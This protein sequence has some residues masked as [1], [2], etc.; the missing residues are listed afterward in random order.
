MKYNVIAYPDEDGYPRQETTIIAANREQAQDKAWRMFPEY[1][2]VAVF[3]E[4]E[5]NNDNT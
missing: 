4:S 1:H 5:D 2:E 3:E